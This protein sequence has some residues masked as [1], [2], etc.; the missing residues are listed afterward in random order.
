MVGQFKFLVHALC[1]SCLDMLGFSIAGGSDIKSKLISDI[2][3]I[4]F[5]ISQCIK[6]RWVI[7]SYNKIVYLSFMTVHI[8]DGMR[9]ETGEEPH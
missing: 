9:V 3:S 2:K 8:C 7:V 6:H 1:C 5:G 4:F